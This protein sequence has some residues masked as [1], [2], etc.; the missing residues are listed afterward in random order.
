MED[1]PPEP[2]PREPFSQG[3]TI[4]HPHGE[5]K[6]R[7]HQIREAVPAPGSVFQPARHI[8]GGQRVDDYHQ[9]QGQSPEVIERRQSLPKFSIPHFS[10]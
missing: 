3:N 10:K 7:G 5:Q 8:V 6:H 2:E 4:G 1:G 9:E